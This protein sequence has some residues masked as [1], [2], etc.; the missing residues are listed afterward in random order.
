MCSTDDPRSNSEDA[1]FTAVSPRAAQPNGHGQPGD[2]HAHLGE[3]AATAVGVRAAH[4]AA[5][6]ADVEGD[7]VPG[8]HRRTAANVDRERGTALP[9]VAGPASMRRARRSATGCSPTTT[10]APRR[11]SP[12]SPP[13]RRRST[14]GGRRSCVVDSG[15]TSA[16]TE[17]VN[18]MVNNAGGSPPG[19]ATWIARRPGTAARHTDE[20]QS[21][22]ARV[23]SPNHIRACLLS[24]CRNSLGVDLWPAGSRAA[25]RWTRAQTSGREV[26]AGSHYSV[27][28]GGLD[29]RGPGGFSLV[30]P[31]LGRPA[32]RPGSSLRGSRTDVGVSREGWSS[33]ACGLLRRC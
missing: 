17:A 23:I 18:S 6:P 13:W 32:E 19:S 7:L 14:P 2:D 10:G 11:R 15:I 33:G 28:S 24:P 26:V 4:S 29:P 3:L 31:F 20:H 27:A 25:A 22:V 16:R 9:A 30:C 1:T 5:V 8:S 21:A 12:R